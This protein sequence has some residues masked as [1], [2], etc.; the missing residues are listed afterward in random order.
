MERIAMATDGSDTTPNP[1]PGPDPTNPP[2]APA[3]TAPTPPRT[4]GEALAAFEAG[5]KDLTTRETDLANAND[6]YKAAVAADQAFT[7]TV[8]AALP[9]V[10][11]SAF[12]M[13]GSQPTVYLMDASADGFHEFK[14]A[15]ADTPLPGAPAPAP[16]PNAPAPAPAPDPNAPAPAPDPNAPA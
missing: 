7:A 8:R 15:P 13:E 11:G 2:P 6:A 4:I 12:T 10:G 3:P 16:D 1:T 14:P 9:Q 5:E